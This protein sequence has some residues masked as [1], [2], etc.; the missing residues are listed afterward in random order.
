MVT[1]AM[2]A[3]PFSTPMGGFSL[4]ARQ[5]AATG[6]ISTV[7]T[8][9]GYP[10][11]LGLGLRAWGNSGAVAIQ[12]ALYI[13]I[14]A[15][16]Y[17]ILRLLDVKRATAVLAAGLVGFHPELIINIKKIWD[18]NITIALLM[19]LC[20]YLLS[21]IRRGLTPSRAA[22]TGIL[23][24]LSINVRPN[25]PALILPIMFAFWCAPAYGN[26]L[27]TLLTCSALTL[28]CA[29]LAV[30]T[31][32][33]LVH[34]SF[35]IPQNGPYNFYAGDNAFSERALL[36]S[37]N[38]EPSIYPSLLADG[39]SS[40]VNIYSADLR[41]YYVQHAL[42]YM[43]QNPLSAV[44]LV[45]LKLGTMLRPDTKIHPV[46]SL[47]GVVK[48]VLALAVPFWV[49]TLVA[50]RGHAWELED[51]LFVTFVIAYMIPFLI[52]NSDPRFRIPL[53]I[54]VL[55]HVIYRWARF[56]PLKQWTMT[57]THDSRNA[58]APKAG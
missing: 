18:T 11:L 12:L 39:F 50:L 48:V 47:G 51:W 14:L 43:R 57:N 55:T 20:G 17:F 34:G 15:A 31:V 38:A 28:V 32:S 56:S 21:I 36:T 26:R 45:V 25:F 52:T 13:S 22:M 1:V 29:V 42:M 24:G 44:K 8:P 40:D 4:D 53:D 19:V 37:L 23:W 2:V 58:L 46:T 30:V 3:V 27:R 41:P 7:F 49:S 54:L 16:V 9:C 6:Q 10:A 5:F 35:Y 33:T